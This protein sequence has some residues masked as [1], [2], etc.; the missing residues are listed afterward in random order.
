MPP[1]PDKEKEDDLFAKGS[2]NEL[3]T[4]AQAVDKAPTAGPPKELQQLLQ[5]LMGGG[6]KGGGNPMDMIGKLLG[7]A[8]GGAPKA[9]TAGSPP[10]DKDMISK[11]MGGIGAKGASPEPEEKKK[12]KKGP[13]PRLLQALMSRLGG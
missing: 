1:M 12:K 8:K 7:G 3:E 9:P 10:M 11:L 6:E 4:F 2:D 5:K 13:N